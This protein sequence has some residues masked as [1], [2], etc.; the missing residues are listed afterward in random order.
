VVVW[1][2]AVGPIAYFLTIAASVVTSAVNPTIL[3]HACMSQE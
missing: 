1:W 2:H 3:Q